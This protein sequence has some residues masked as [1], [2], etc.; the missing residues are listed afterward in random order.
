MFLT[1]EGLH[2][3]MHL[4]TNVPI[5]KSVVLVYITPLYIHLQFQYMKKLIVMLH[6][7]PIY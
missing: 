3:V 7:S 6:Y 4:E 5:L 1:T 2:L